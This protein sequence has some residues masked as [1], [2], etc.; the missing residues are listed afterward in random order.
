M[1]FDEPKSLLIRK[2][3]N[4]LEYNG[5]SSILPRERIQSVSSIEQQQAIVSFEAGWQN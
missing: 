4:K 1:P 2:L 3:K 5:D